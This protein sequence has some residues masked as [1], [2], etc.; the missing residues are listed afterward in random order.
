MSGFAE[1][2]EYPELQKFNGKLYTLNMSGMVGFAK[3]LNLQYSGNSTGNSI[4]Y[5]F[6][7]F[8]FPEKFNIS[9]SENSTG[10]CVH[11]I[12]TERLDLQKNCV[13]YMY[14]MLGLTEKLHIQICKNLTGNCVDYM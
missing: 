4:Q 11:Y 13:R 12:R 7:M 6:G 1:E 10:N 2:I 5:M 9:N 3:K 8:G 14:V